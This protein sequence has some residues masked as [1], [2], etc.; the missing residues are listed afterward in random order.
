MHNPSA[1]SSAVSHAKKSKLEERILNLL[2]AY[3]VEVIHQYTITKEPHSHAYDFY[4]PKYKL[5]IDADGIYY[6]GYVNDPDGRHIR[7]DYDGVRLS[8][9]PPD[10][11]FHVIVERN[12]ESD[13]KWLMEEICGASDVSAKYDSELFAWCRTMEFPYPQYSERRLSSDFGRLCGYF[14]KMHN[15]YAKTGDSIVRSFHKSLYDK[16]HKGLMSPKQAWRDD[17]ALESIISKNLIYINKIDPSKALQSFNLS[18]VASIIT[19]FAPTSAKYVVMKYLSEFDFVFDPASG[20]SERML[21]VAAS[22]KKYV[23]F[24]ADSLL[25]EES[26]QIIGFLGLSNCSVQHGESLEQEY[27]CM[28]TSPPYSVDDSDSW[29]ADMMSKYACKRYVFV[30][31]TTEKYKQN[32]VETL[33]SASHLANVQEQVIVIDI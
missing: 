11:T 10:H 25:V 13:V 7:D 5:L 16:A 19:T 6:H 17:S 3:D 27:P 30:V 20:F 22:G 29:I 12:E 9:I 18:N 2:K 15:P 1:R 14:P 28:F 33:N 31:D 32:V 24:D 23:G 26:N 21:G 4:L 8:L